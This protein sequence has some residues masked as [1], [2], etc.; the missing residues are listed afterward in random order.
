LITSLFI[1]DYSPEYTADKASC[2]YAIRYPLYASI[3]RNVAG[4][5]SFSAGPFGS[6]PLC[7]YTLSMLESAGGRTGWQRTQGPE[8]TLV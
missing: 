6:T 4:I 7:S 3:Y 5:G 1:S 8:E 2:L